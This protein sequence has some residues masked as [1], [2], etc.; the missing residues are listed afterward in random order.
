ARAAPST[1]GAFDRTV[2]LEDL[3]HRLDAAA[4]FV[5]VE[6][7]LLHRHR[8]AALVEQGD[9]LLRLLARGKGDPDEVVLDLAVLV[10]AQQHTK[11]LVEGAP[12]ATDLLVVR[13]RRARAL[14]VH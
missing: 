11:G 10:A 7:D 1:F 6:L 2:D 4:P 14:V 12:G 3:Q 5:D 13:D 8:S 9:D